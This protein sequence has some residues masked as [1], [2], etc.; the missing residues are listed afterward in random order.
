MLE[1]LELTPWNPVGRR[2]RT[3]EV[4][5]PSRNQGDI[6]RQLR[7]VPVVAPKGSLVIFSGAL[8]HG[9]YRKTTPGL[10]VTMLGQHCRPYMRPF[11]DFK[12]KLPEQIFASSEDPAYLRTLLLEGQG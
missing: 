12:G 4:R 6:L 3:D 9:A 8:W 11:E 5:G 2:T 7:D 10:R 1:K